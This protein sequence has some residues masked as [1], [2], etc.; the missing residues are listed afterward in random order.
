MLNITEKSSNL[1]KDRK[2][3]T[4]DSVSTL[5]NIFANIMNSK[6]EH[7][8]KIHQLEGEL[9]KAKAE[10]RTRVVN[11]PGNALPSRGGYG[12][13]AVQDRHNLLPPTGTAKKLYSEAV[14]TSVENY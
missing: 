1:R 7:T 12:Q 14:N 11:P 13:S 6:E 3:D 10:I 4:V 5:R 9:N 8:R 2:K